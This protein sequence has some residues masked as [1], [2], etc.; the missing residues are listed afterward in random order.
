MIFSGDDGQLYEAKYIADQ[1]G[2]RIRGTYLVPAADVKVKSVDEPD[3]DDL[4]PPA[5]L[6]PS[7]VLSLVG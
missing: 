6:P 1:N 5:A 2:F 7:A 3:E 4:P